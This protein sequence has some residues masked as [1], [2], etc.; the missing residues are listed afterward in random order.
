MSRKPGRVG[1]TGDPEQDRLLVTLQQLLALEATDLGDALQ[2]TCNPVGE[3]LGADKV[4]VFLHDPAIE[5]LVAVG[6]SDTPMGR[7]QHALGLDRLPL[8]NGGRT[9]EVYQTGRP[10][11]TGHADQDPGVLVGVREALG[12]RSMIVVPLDIAGALRGVLSVTSAQPERFAERDLPFLEAVSDWVGMVAHRAELVERIAGEAAQQGRRGVVDELVTVLAHDLRNYLTA[13]DGHVTLLRR[14][15]ERER[16][17][18]DLENATAASRVVERLTRLVVDLLD[19]ARLEQGLFAVEPQPVDLVA[20]AAEAAEIFATETTA[21]EV[22]AP[23]ELVVGADPDRLRQ[24]LANLLA[25]AVRYSPAGAPV[26]VE[27][28]REERADGPW[29]CVSVRD[30]GPG[31]PPDLLP[32]LFT[33]FAAGRGRE[34]GLGLGLY[35]ARGIATAHGG[36]LAVESSPG[37]GARFDLALPI[38]Q[39]VAGRPE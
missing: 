38:D 1:A 2:R 18:R 22:W 29:A 36:T 20:L 39:A 9:V 17:P 27:V 33:R 23:D 35:L 28:A 8:A 13:L 6:T 19:T 25:N 21:I 16:R 31:I 4:D 5:T 32:R 12:V 37:A 10:Y 11:Y 3:A 15:A 34:A 24:A 14:R 26:V 7:R 30:R